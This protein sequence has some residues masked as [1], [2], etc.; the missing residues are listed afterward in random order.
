MRTNA[1]HSLQTGLIAFHSNCAEDLARVVFAWMHKNPLHALEEEIIL[2]QSIGMAEWVKMELARA[3]GVCAAARVELPSRFMWRTFR[4]VLG[5]QAVPSDSPLDKVPMTWR[6]MQLLP[7]LLGE[8]VFAPVAGFLAAKEPQRMLQLAS[9]L[10]DLFDQYQNYRADWLQ[11]W[12]DGQDTIVLASGKNQEL[13]ADQRWQAHLWRAVLQALG[14]HAQQHIRPRLHQRVLNVLASGQA[15]AQP[16]ARRVTVF[17]MSQVPWSTMELLAGLAPHS[18]V[19]LAIPNPCRFYWGDIMDGRELLHAGRRRQAPRTLAGQPALAPDTRALEDMHAHAHPLLAAW[20]RQSRD[21]IR[22]LDVFDDV[23]QSRQR[24]QETRLDL[25]GDQQEQADDSLLLRVQKRIRDLV[26]LHEGL[27]APLRSQDRS[28]VFHSAHSPVR[29]LEILHDQLLHLLAT[30]GDAALNPREVVVMVPDIEAMAPAIRAVFGQYKRQDPRFIPFDIADLGALASSPLIGALAWLLQLPQQRCRMSELFDLLEVPAIAA[31]FGIAQDDVPRLT[32]WMTGAGIRWG[33]HAGHRADLGMAACGDQN[34]AWFGLRRMLLGFAN[35]AV[36]VADPLPSLG[37][38]E[39]YAE[40]GGLDAELAGSLAQMLQ[41]L[42]HWWVQARC[43]G[44]PAQWM[45]RCEALLQSMVL[46]QSDTDRLALRALEVGLRDWLLAC[47]HAAFDQEVPLVVARAAWLQAVE[48]PKMNQ[49]FRAGGVTFCTLMPMRAIPFEVVCLLGMND[50][51]YPRH[52]M[53][54]DFDLMGQ[55][56]LGRPGDRSRKDDDRQLM[57]ESLLSA[58]RVLYVSWCGHSVRDNSAQAPS[59]LVSQ[60]RDYLSAAWGPAAVND[61]STEHPLQ[62]FSRR[63]FESASPLFTY[64]RE[65]RTLH[66]HASHPQPQPSSPGTLWTPDPHV[67][68]TLDQLTQF[69][70]N[71]V[72]AFF[73]QRLL[74]RFA[75]EEDTASDDECF[76]L[77]G[78]ERYRLVDR[79]LA[80]GTASSGLQSGQSQM[81]ASLARLRKAGALPLQGLADLEQAALHEGL[82]RMLGAWYGALSEY[83]QAAPRQSIRLEEGPVLVQDWIDH[84]RHN[85]GTDTPP[86]WLELSAGTLCEPGKPPLARADKLLGYWIR[87]LAAAAGGHS[88]AGVV[89]GRDAVLHISAMVEPELAQSTLRMLLQLW[90]DGMNAPLALPPK[91]ALAWIKGKETAAKYRD[92]RAQYQGGHHHIGEVQDPCLARVYPDFQALVHDGRFQ[93][94]AQQVYGPLLAWRSQHVLAQLLEPTQAEAAEVPA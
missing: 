36:A 26:P 72:K 41:A 30:S 63:Y 17:G 10:A 29:E 12:A 42:D 79:L 87:S 62:A 32:Q 65:W 13:A 3:G 67:P 83:P 37:A 8:A 21:F 74:V 11:A 91:T 6:L 4:Q 47:E 73:R 40:V 61:R 25:F 20:G 9:Q 90:L 64:A 94:L 55:A 15:L 18:Q 68:L 71:P 24:F 58:R 50:G 48:T 69:V 46:A 75:P 23:E 82:G 49:R 84:L 19:M 31:R 85:G 88:V 2:V 93:Q 89:V 66:Q 70:R 60:L 59:V 52:D 80:S 28:I 16:V 57:L 38:I 7:T 35:G 81:D 51:D 27:A 54:N 44:T 92:A 78:L 34:S 1:S 43:D 14:E 5:P 45:Q 76:G 56:G 86:A 22:L 33:L 53:R 77:V 39:P